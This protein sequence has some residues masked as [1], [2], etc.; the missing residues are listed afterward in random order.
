[1]TN[2]INTIIT[3]LNA[4]FKKFVFQNIFWLG[5]NLGDAKWYIHFGLDISSFLNAK[6]FLDLCRNLK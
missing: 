6:N 5:K 3:V 1:M 4:K 2:Q